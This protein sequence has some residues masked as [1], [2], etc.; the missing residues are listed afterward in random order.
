[1]TVNY[2]DA[3]IVGGGFGGITQ[4]FK[5]RESGLLVHGFERGSFLGGVWHHNRYPGARVDSEIPCYQLWLKETCKGWLFSERFPGWKELQDYFAFVDT[6]I[7]VSQDYSFESNVEA[8]HWN[9]TEKLWDITVTGKGSGSYK[10]KYLILCTGFASKKMYP[11]VK[12]RDMFKGVSFHTADWP[13][14]GIDIKKKKVAVIGTGASGVQVVQEIGYD[15]EELVVFQ[16]TP[17]TAIPMRQ[18]PGNKEEQIRRR[19]AYPDL[20]ERL[21]STS[22]SGFEYNRDTRLAKDCTPEEIKAQ[23]DDC[24]EKGGFRFWEGNFDD[25]LTDKSS[26]R[27]AYD[28]WRNK[29]CER[30]KDPRKQKLLAPEKQL[31]PIFAKRPSLEQRYYEVF[32][33]DNVNIVDIRETPILEITENGLKT[34]EKE[35]E[36]DIIIYATG[37]DAVTG[38]FYQI[39]LIG[40]N[41]ATLKDQWK[42]GT[43]TYLGMTIAEFSNLFFLYGPQG[44]SAFCNGP[45]CCLIQA[46]WIRDTIKYTEEHGYK[47]VTTTHKAQESWRKYIN[48]GANKTLLPLADSWYMG[49]SREGKKPKECLLY[50]YG[51]NNY[52]KDINK[53][54]LEN[55]YKNFEFS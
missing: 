21:K 53:E 48:D 37:F 17:N 51:V 45:T 14:E 41:G 38:G 1:M 34:S 55:N 32:N 25:L 39:D 2:F 9:E 29:V 42:D 18:R 16:R 8:S 52:Y 3:I 13:W 10:C 19:D 4:L 22:L 15:V 44:P 54:R 35:Y 6:Q 33:Q 24:W 50:V 11:K 43:Y 12:N 26:N 5:L 47:T 20:F 27:L 7:N 31:H 23:F 46:E 40:A 28:Y 36:F 49:M 30:V